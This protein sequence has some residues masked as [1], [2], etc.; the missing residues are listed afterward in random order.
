MIVH[1]FL[2]PQQ[3]LGLYGWLQRFWRLSFTHNQQP[4]NLG[5][6]PLALFETFHR[7]TY[8]FGLIVRLLPPNQ[9][10]H[11]F[12]PCLCPCGAYFVSNLWRTVEVL[13]KG[14]GKEESMASNGQ[15]VTSPQ[16]KMQVPQ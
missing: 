14:Q 4:L 13:Q 9:C 6:W 12:S 16:S 5:G 1:Q 2:A 10:L 15:G 8:I 11:C 3:E 7:G